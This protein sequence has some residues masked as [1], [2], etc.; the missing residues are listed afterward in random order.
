M[1]LK[2]I[3]ADCKGFL[4]HFI[5]LLFFFFSFIF[6]VFF[7]SLPVSCHPR[8]VLLYQTL[9]IWPAAFMLRERENEMKS[10][11]KFVCNKV[12]IL[13]LYCLHLT[14]NVALKIVYREGKECFN[15]IERSQ[16]TR[17]IHGRK[18]FLI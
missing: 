17:S 12:K 8:L 1:L 14:V 3:R 6:P 9:R 10:C 2:Q 5:L 13:A 7:I 15:K 11:V 18:F 4:V 16:F